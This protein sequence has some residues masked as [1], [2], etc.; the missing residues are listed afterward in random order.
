MNAH[1]QTLTYIEICSFHE[2]GEGGFGD[3]SMLVRDF[4]GAFVRPF[5]E[6][7]KK[8]YGKPVTSSHGLVFQL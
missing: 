8:S 3:F 5:L 6:Y 4:K 2:E 7:I 1:A